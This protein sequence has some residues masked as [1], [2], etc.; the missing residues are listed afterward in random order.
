M[1]I[2]TNGKWSFKNDK[3]IINVVHMT[4]ALYSEHYITHSWELVRDTAM[5]DLWTMNWFMNDSFT[6]QNQFSSIQLKFY[7]QTQLLLAEST[8][9]ISLS[10]ALSHMTAIDS[11]VIVTN[12]RVITAV[13]LEHYLY[14]LAVIT[15]ANTT[16]YSVFI[17]DLFSYMLIFSWQGNMS[18]AVSLWH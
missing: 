18:S 9:K 17:L 1:K 2:P 15:W 14:I 3:R 12:Q 7:S 10:D 5:A 4:H 11:A 16:W 6:N 13:K 8:Y